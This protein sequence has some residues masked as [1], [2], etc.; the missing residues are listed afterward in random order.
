MPLDPALLPDGNF[1]Q[2]PGC[3]VA[4]SPPR[5]TANWPAAAEHE[6]AAWE[7]DRSAPVD[8]AESTPSSPLATV[9]QLLNSVTPLVSLKLANVSTQQPYISADSLQIPGL[10]IN[11]NG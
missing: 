3:G 6:L 4:H 10:Q 2:S 11:A 5:R 8:P 1:R 7:P 9:L